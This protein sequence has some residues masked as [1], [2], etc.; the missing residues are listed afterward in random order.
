MARRL[1][2]GAIW[3]ALASRLFGNMY[4][5]VAHVCGL[6]QRLTGGNNHQTV[7]R[8]HKVLPPPPS[9]YQLRQSPKGPY[10]CCSLD[11]AVDTQVQKEKIAR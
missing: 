11:Q 9:L 4:K 5:N 3:L 10:A 2:S 1:A 6:M 7:M 8:E